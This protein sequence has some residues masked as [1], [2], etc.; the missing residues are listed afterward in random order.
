MPLV[1][2]AADSGGWRLPFLVIGSLLAACTL[3]NWFWFPKSAGAGLRSFSFFSR[4]RSLLAIPI[5][6][7][8]LAV[9]LAQRTAYLAL[10]SYLGAYLIDA[11][12]MT[13]GAVALPL[14]FVGIGT[15]VGSYVGGPVANR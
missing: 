9:N 3:L 5:F 2:V 13:V 7:A 1:A 4:Y 14:T 11:Y 10:Y 8:A 6:R 12:G 15:V